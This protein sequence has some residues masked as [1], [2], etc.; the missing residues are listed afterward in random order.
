MSA[1]THRHVPFHDTLPIEDARN[2]THKLI[3]MALLLGVS[4]FA[5]ALRLHALDDE[6]LW[7]DEF[8]QVS[9]YSL[10]L[11]YVA[12]ESARIT[13]PPLDIFIGA[14][15]HRIGLAEHDG[16]VRVPA[17]LFGAGGVFLLGWWIRKIAGGPAGVA[18]ALLLA[19]CPL[20]LAMSQEAR[21][22]T[23]L[24]FLSL[25]TLATFARAHQ[26]NTLFSWSVFS[27]RGI[28]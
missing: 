11:S 21:P 4:V 12:T 10:P 13:Q 6:S 15:L 20:H 3:S 25:L 2:P 24:F 22:Y 26:R 16:W 9:L 23:L 17:A 18:A 7:I 1:A 19:V 5:L 28:P 14:A 8:S 27:G